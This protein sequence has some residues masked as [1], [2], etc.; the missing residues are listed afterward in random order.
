MNVGKKEGSQIIQ[1]FGRGVRLKGK[2]F[3]L[4]RSR[5]IDAPKDMERLETLNVFGVHANYMKQFKEYLE[6]EGL[7]NNDDRIEFVLPVIKNLGSTQLKTIRVKDGVDFKKQG[8]KPTLDI[9]D[10]LFRRNRVV[11]DWYP[12]IQSLTSKKKQELDQDTSLNE[13]WFKSEHMAFIEFDAL[14]FDLQQMKSE[15]AWYNL[16]LSREK[17]WNLLLDDGWYVLLIPSEEMEA[18]SFEKVN[19]WQEMASSLLRKYCDRFYKHR[20]AEFEKDHLEYQTLTEDDP[21]F[22]DEYRFLVDRSREDIVTKLK[23]ISNAMAKGELSALSFQ[24]LKTLVFDKHLYQPLIHVNN[25]QIDIKP[26]ALNPGEKDFVEDLQKFCEGEPEL[27]KDKELYFLRNMSRGRGIGF[28]EAGNFYPDFILWL[29][30]G[31]KQCINFIDPKG[32][33]NLKGPTD[34]KI[35]FYKTIKNLEFDLDSSKKKITLNSFIIA[36]TRLSEVSHW[37]TGMDLADFENINVLFQTEDK[38]AYVGK[39][40]GNI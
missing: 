40:L 35:E 38:D 19:R 13:T 37:N 6:D 33:R 4:K 16:N 24:G 28:F 29:L 18:T 12:K 2:G 17:L 14:Y 3:S 5:G 32:I 22:I 15:R 10:T 26:V 1:L 7:P 27:L 31:D 30:E 8:I 20:K 34:P 36:N 21:N 25:N 39:L 11:I 23:E 9:P